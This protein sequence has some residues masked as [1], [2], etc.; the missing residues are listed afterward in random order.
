M[1]PLQE[2]AEKLRDEV[3]KVTRESLQ[4]KLN[5]AKIAKVLCM[6]SLMASLVCCERAHCCVMWGRGCSL[7][8]EVALCQVAN[9]PSPRAQAARASL[10]PPC[11][12]PSQACAAEWCV[13][14]HV[15]CVWE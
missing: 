15:A 3:D 10:S 6:P 4:L 2:E 9:L 12:P 14:V 11:Y 1:C 13:A 8:C 5:T 7:P